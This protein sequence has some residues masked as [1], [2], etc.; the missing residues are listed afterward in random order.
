MSRKRETGQPINAVGAI[1]ETLSGTQID[2]VEQH[3]KH[4]S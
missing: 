1:I 3:T 4:F 2:F